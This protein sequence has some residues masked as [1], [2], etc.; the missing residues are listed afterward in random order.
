LASFGAAKLASLGAA[1]FCF[2]RR[3]AIWLRS[4]HTEIGFGR[5]I[6]KLASVGAILMMVRIA[7][8]P[9]QRTNRH[10]HYRVTPG[11]HPPKRT[12]CR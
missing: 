1:R 4:A 7:T 6:P 2:A 5:R 11:D 8:D 3:R 10:N 12:A 9:Y